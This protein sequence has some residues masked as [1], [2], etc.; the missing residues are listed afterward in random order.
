[1]TAAAAV[2]LPPMGPDEVAGRLDAIAETFG[3]ADV[4]GCAIVDGFGVRLRVER[5]ALEVADGIGPHRRLR[6]YDRATH[7][8]ARVV[9][10]N[11]D[12]IVSLAA[13]RWADALGVPVY[14]FGADGRCQVASTPKV[15]DDA[16][17][18]RAQALAPYGPEGLAVTKALLG[19]KLAGQAKV[20][21]GRFGAHD[22]ATT[23]EA[24]ADRLAALST[25]D[26]PGVAD[27]ARE[28]LDEARA[29]EATA[30]AVYWGA[31]AGRPE[32]VPVFVPRDRA[33]VP[34]HWR[35]FETRR[36]LLGSASGNRKAERP[37]NAILNY[38]NGLLEAEAI[39]ACAA[40]GLDA[41]LGVVHL[42]A[43]GRASMALDLM[44]PVRPLVED[45]V[46]DL[47]A[48]RTFRKL[49]LVET[50]DG[51]CRLTSP[52]THELAATLP[53]WRDAVAPWA[54]RV[55]A[56]IGAAIPGSFTA[57]APLTG[58]HRRA[59]AARVS[60]RKA[61]DDVLGATR[62]DLAQR[63]ATSATRR[64]RPVARKAAPRGCVDCG[65][66]VD[67]PRRVRCPE[68]IAADPRQTPEVRSRRGRAIAARKAA[69]ATQ[70]AAGLPPG[71]DAAWYRREVL[72]RLAPL[73]LSQL[74]EASGYSKGHCSNL[75]A[76]K[77][78]PHPSTWPALAALAGVALTEKA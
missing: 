66:L 55:A 56:I 74:V 4:A 72:P 77:F 51:A 37:V 34:A 59:A 58:R 32:A 47:L 6:R 65:Q 57:R 63:R 73:K 49:E 75:R 20:L 69:L 31:W 13:F 29:I 11:A 15:G 42:D 26:A 19:A 43:A 48:G 62:S 67:S 17:L 8:L 9:I 35:S 14:L 10:L 18:R 33:R 27:E 52:L 38:C 46:L 36:S 71:C 41:G 5:G 78:T 2:L 3:R 22:E 16:R 7:G 40:V 61:G 25:I 60:A 12:G 54:E 70:D 68:C 39:V 53:R 50:P 44:E 45:H 64:Q 23:V 1:M 76:G 28:L 30:A 24:L 21:R